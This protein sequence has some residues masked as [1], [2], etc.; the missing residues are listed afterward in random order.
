MSAVLP[1]APTQFDKSAH[2][3]TQ[4]VELAPHNLF[5]IDQWHSGSI[6]QD[7]GLG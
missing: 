6:A 4:S 3:E 7:S 2:L 1:E 5:L